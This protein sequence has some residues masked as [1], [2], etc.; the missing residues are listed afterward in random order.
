ME[1]REEFSDNEIEH[2]IATNLTGSIVFIQSSLPY[3][4]KQRSG[5]II[6]ISSW[7]DR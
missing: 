5:R 7:Q 4:R 3:L 2:V 1:Q 6:Q